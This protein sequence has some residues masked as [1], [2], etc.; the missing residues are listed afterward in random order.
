[1][2]IVGWIIQ[3]DPTDQGDRTSLCTTPRNP[4]FWTNQSIQLI[5]TSFGSPSTSAQ[6][7][8]NATIQVTLY[9][10]A[11]V[12]YTNFVTSI[13]AWVCYPNTIPG[14]PNHF[15]LNA[16]VP[17]MN[18]SAPGSNAPPSWSGEQYLT[19]SIQPNVPEDYLG[20][21]S[22]TPTWQP[23]QDDI[24][25]APAGLQGSN[26]AHTCIIATSAGTSDALS[27][28]QSPVGYSAPGTDP[29]GVDV[30]GSGFAG[31]LNIHI[32]GVSKGGQ[33]RP[34]GN[35]AGGLAFL[36]GV[37]QAGRQ[38]NLPVAVNLVSQ[39]ALIDPG[40]LK[41][42]QSGPYGHLPLKPSSTPPL[43]F[44][45]MKNGHALHHRWL[46]QFF[47]EIEH[48]LKEIWDDIQHLLAG[49]LIPSH[50][51]PQQS[52]NVTV[53]SSGIAPLLFLGQ[54]DPS[55]AVGN[56]HVFDVVQTDPLTGK[57]GGIRIAAVVTS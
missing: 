14:D 35:L 28:S 48:E 52:I 49:T 33:I 51:H 9:A 1:M 34:G 30:C 16:V 19:A 20:P 40:L 27:D 47:K 57:Q 46:C 15:N 5:N 29:T 43:S 54:F 50:K 38:T 7:G 37:A 22:L 23:I 31:Q 12:S 4:P 42:L 41:F 25:E 55:E 11:G 6:V 10:G 44:G 24:L 18:P 8:D 39:G 21:T 17:S 45:L 3:I 2:S 26:E 36:A 56:V 53:P 32:I 13:Q